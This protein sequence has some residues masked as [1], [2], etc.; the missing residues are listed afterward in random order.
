M[1]IASKALIEE[2]KNLRRII[3]FILSHEPLVLLLIELLS[4]VSLE[5]LQG[6]SQVR[7]SL[8][9]VLKE[10]FVIFLGIVESG[11]EDGSAHF[12]LILLE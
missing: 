3:D 6:Y 4:L 9:T 5:L 8:E 2:L 1:H 10:V 11:K 12:V 7:D